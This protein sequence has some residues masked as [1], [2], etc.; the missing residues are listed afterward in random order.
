MLLKKYN[1]WSTANSE[2]VP[3]GSDEPGDPLFVL[4][5]QTTSFGNFLSI[6][7]QSAEIPVS[8]VRMAINAFLENPLLF[9]VHQE[10]F[11]NG[12]GAFNSIAD[13]VNRI[14]PD[15]QWRNLGE[16][17]RHSYL[18]R[19]RQDGDYDVLALSANLVFTNPNDRAVTLVSG[20]RRLRC[21]S[22]H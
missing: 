14:A 22:G 4:R 7:R 10:F 16:I 5:P 9:Y 19:L 6:K 21:P 15:T 20:E 1:Y 12:I 11:G 17:S 18:M 13:Q 2:N 3:L 8:S